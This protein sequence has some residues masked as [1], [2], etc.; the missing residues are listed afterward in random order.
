VCLH[1]KYQGVYGS[2]REACVCTVNIKVFRVQC[3]SAVNIKVF[4]V[5][6]ARRVLAQYISR[7]LWF[8]ACIVCL[9]RKY[10]GVY[11]SVRTARV[12]TVNIKVFMVQLAL[13]SLNT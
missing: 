12:C 10:Q 9:H 4:M 5:H 13:F 6:C 1:S 11:G 3:A 2:V 7:C 8:C